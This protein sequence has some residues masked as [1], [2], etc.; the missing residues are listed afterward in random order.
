MERSTT[1]EP[2]LIT[3]LPF[4][5]HLPFHW[6][7]NTDAKNAQ[8][9]SPSLCYSGNSGNF[10]NFVRYLPQMQMASGQRAVRLN[11]SRSSPDYPS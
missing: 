6:S 10:L 4:A 5:F 11:T 8:R 1:V 9:I 7:G 2:I 3:M